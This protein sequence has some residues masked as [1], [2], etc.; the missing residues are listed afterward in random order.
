MTFSMSIT[1]SILFFVFIG[2]ALV[3]CV[4]NPI[5]GRQQA[6]VVSDDQAALESAQSYK[7][8]IGES[9]KNKAL[10][11]DPAQLA[12]IKAIT[13]PLIHEASAFRPSAASWNWEVHVLKS[14]EINAWCMAGGKMAIYTGLLNKLNPTDDEIAAVMGHE[15]SHALLSHQAEKL[16]RSRM[17]QVGVSAGV[18]AGSLFGVNLSG[19]APVANSVAEVGLQLPNS[20]EAETEADTVGLKLAAQAGYNPQAAVSLWT[21]MLALEGAK[22]PEW[23][24]THP[25]T[26]TRLAHVK[27]EADKLMPIYQ[28]ALAKKAPK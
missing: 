28:D 16:S 21:K 5:T 18:I 24:S 14:D 4:S 15:I 7:Q 17:Q 2:L 12:R 8:L 11:E 6:M 3:G 20:R 10:D 1:K 13:D 23:L 19:L 9:D 25:D 22:A 27:E 26:R